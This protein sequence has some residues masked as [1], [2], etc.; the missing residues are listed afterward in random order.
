MEQLNDAT[1]VAQ[2]C[3]GE[4]AFF[5]ELV[6]RYESLARVTALRYVSDHHSADDIVQQS[7]V[8]A[9]E[10]I[11]SLRDRSKFAGWL[12]R[13]VQREAYRCQRINQRKRESSDIE[14]LVA[15]GADTLREDLQEAVYLL[16]QLP[17]HERIVMS[18]HHL[19]GKSISEI[20]HMTGRPLGT[21]SK[22]LS[23]ATKRIQTLASRRERQHEH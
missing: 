15:K 10:E 7:F 22:Q 19:D 14:G 16:N 3:A 20:A 6:I 23:R 2:V 17:S 12:L 1:L 9:F 5:G 11:A 13:I 18:L 8:R 4:T 21:V